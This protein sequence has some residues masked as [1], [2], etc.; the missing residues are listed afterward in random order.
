MVL[1]S[2]K[3]FQVGSGLQDRNEAREGGSIR[4]DG[5]VEHGE[6]EPEEGTLHDEGGVTSESWRYL[7]RLKVKEQ[8]DT[9]LRT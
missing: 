6:L 4:C 7:Q 5:N 8:L 1:K 2:R 3:M 9:S